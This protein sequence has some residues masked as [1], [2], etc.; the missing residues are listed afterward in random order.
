MLIWLKD[1]PVFNNTFGD[2]SNQQEVCNFVDKLVTCRREWDGT[3]HAKNL[4]DCNEDT[5]SALVDS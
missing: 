4:E 3:P 2:D 1:A 5:W